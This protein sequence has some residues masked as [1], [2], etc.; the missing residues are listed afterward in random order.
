MTV[1]PG[2]K[3]PEVHADNELTD[4]VGNQELL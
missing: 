2:I 1:T 3:A 4:L